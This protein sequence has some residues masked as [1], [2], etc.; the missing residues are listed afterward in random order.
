MGPDLEVLNGIPVQERAM[1]RAFL[2]VV[3][4]ALAGCAADDAIITAPA[5][6]ASG[7][8][9]AAPP[10]EGSA[11]AISANIQGSHVPFGT[12]IDPVYASGDPASPGFTTLV[13][14]NRSAD[15]AI[16]TGHYL[17]AE[18]FR[19]RVTGSADALANARRT[20]DAI[21]ALL[22]VPGTGVLARFTVPEA[23][24][25]ADGI[26]LGEAQHGIYPGTVDGVT[27]CWL[28]NT[29]RDQYSGVFFG[30]GVAYDMVGD[31]QTQAR[32]RSLVTRMLDFLI[33]N[34]WNVAMPPRP[35]ANAC[36]EGSAYDT[37]STTFLQRPEQR[38]SFLQVGRHVNPRRF[39]AL[40]VAERAA[41]A[42]TVSIPIRTEC[43]DTHGSYY[44]FNLDH[45][46]LYNLVRLEEPAS[47]YRA[48]YVEAFEALRA[49][50]G[51]HQ[52]AHFNMIARGLGTAEPARDA[53]TA[54]L[55]GLWLQRP[56]RDYYTDL[57]G[58]YP[59]CGDRACE[60]I[61][62]HDRV[63]TDFLWQRSPFQL[64]GGK[65]GTIETAAIDY[66]LP[67]WMARYY[68]VV[69]G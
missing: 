16:W 43:Q 4:L 47:P 33:R 21:A 41:H 31:V 60:P 10:D 48:L 26:L 59:V 53:E 68:G 61:P 50:T 57:S 42:A 32:V 64:S 25:W 52:N 3:L 11:L 9:T 13:G 38:L 6:H 15:A 20:V 67:Y 1:F 29:S 8:V 14:Y 62:V 22:D 30:L 5:T 24:P 27:H 65:D 2:C 39:E 12:V 19:Y 49:C 55:L 44:K 36:P 35:A 18:A 40:Y 63:N 51:S 66:I 28:G 34:G 58:S 46:N 54:E 56:R 17:A 45:V 23:S 7:L 69:A 37:F